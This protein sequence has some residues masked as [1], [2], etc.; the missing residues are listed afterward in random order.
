M[1]CQEPPQ[2]PQGTTALV[3]YYSNQLKTIG[4]SIAV[5]DVYRINKLYT[6]ISVLE[7]K[8]NHSKLN[9]QQLQYYEE[10]LEKLKE[11]DKL[12]KAYYNA[13]NMLLHHNVQANHEEVITMH[14]I[15][16]FL[17][18]YNYIV[19]TLSCSSQFVYQ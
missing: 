14:S 2:I 10:S 5:Y 11:V 13:I 12:L 19:S 6:H 17:G 4:K 18:R 1:I 9:E 16:K 7:E 8:M 3:V 15:K